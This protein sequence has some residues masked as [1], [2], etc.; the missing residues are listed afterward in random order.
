MTL[1]PGSVDADGNVIDYRGELHH[2]G[3]CFIPDNIKPA[4]KAVLGSFGWCKVRAADWPCIMP[5]EGVACIVR[6]TVK[7][8]A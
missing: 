3:P 1:L 7:P 6:E 8:T 2:D 5:V 4:R